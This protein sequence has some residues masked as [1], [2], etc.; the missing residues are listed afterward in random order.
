M[1]T[2]LVLG[3]AASLW[4]FASATG[5]LAQGAAA[6]TENWLSRFKDSLTTP[7][8][9]ASITVHQQ[10]YVPV[11]SSVAGAGG[12]SRLDFSATLAIRNTSA[13]KPLVVEHIDY[14]DTAGNLIE[15]YVDHP[16][17]VKPYA[18]IEVM[19]AT[20]DVRGGTGASFVVAWG[21]VGPIEEPVIQA[22][23][24]GVSGPR[25]F[26]FLAP[27]QRVRTSGE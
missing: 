22:V 15:R 6:P 12:L 26:S 2:L 8:E 9:P 17:A 5:S 24:I 14:R 20:A 13:S 18:T 10:T 23:M 11:Y 1:R 16:V 3:L 4:I 19:I 21:A 7:P 27:V 25:S